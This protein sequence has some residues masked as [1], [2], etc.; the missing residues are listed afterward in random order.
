MGEKGKIIIHLEKLLAKSGLSKNKFCQR[1]ELQRGQL[2]A[3]LHNT[4]TRLDM[5]V[6]ARMCHT[7]GCDVS[8]LLEYKKPKKD[9]RLPECQMKEE[10]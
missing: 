5:D 1:S 2:N 8:E 4:I 3:Y 10:R 7:L 6:L 9:R